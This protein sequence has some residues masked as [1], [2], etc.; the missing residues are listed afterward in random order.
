MQ[1]LYLCLFLLIL[2]GGCATPRVPFPESELDGLQLKGDKTV[3]G[4]V[5]LVDQL[6]EEQ[7]GAGFEVTLEPVSSYSDQWYEVVYLNNR[8]LK[9]ADPQY[10][11][12]V[13][14]VEADEQGKYILNNVAPG[15]YYLSSPFF[16]K[17]ITCSANIATTKI[18]I[19]KKISIKAS[20]RVLEIPLTKEFTSP[21]LIC[22]LYNQGDW[23]KE[24]PL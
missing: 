14:R 13:L 11:N 18:L 2:V 23:E 20:D 15:D 6:E 22:D 8:S 3:R 16:W 4:R 21:T 5:F 10:N 19:S 1:K 9:K 24:D 12:Y 17:A 7:I